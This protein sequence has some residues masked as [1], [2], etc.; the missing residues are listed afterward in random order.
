MLMKVAYKQIKVVMYVEHELNLAYLSAN[1]AIQRASACMQMIVPPRGY[2][3]KCKCWRYQSHSGC[4][5][6]YAQTGGVSVLRHLKM[7][8]CTFILC[9][10]GGV[11]LTYPSVFILLF[12]IVLYFCLC[13]CGASLHSFSISSRSAIFRHIRSVSTPQTQLF[14]FFYHPNSQ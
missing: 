3:K 8:I 5:P 6:S 10:T 2:H 7:I 4:T 9:Y 12:H 1:F 14:I 11:S 13:G